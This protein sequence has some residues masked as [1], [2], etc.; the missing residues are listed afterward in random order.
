[1][2]VFSDERIREPANQR[3]IKS[4]IIDERKKNCYLMLIFKFH[5]R[6]WF[7]YFFR[8]TKKRRRDASFSV[9]GGHPIA[10]F[11]VIK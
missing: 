8:R 9:I 10:T 4:K 6:L 11:D 3:G 2:K 7:I 5:F 1:M